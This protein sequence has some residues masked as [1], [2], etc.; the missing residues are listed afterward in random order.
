MH[1]LF[2]NEPTT[3]RGVERRF[4]RA[5]ESERRYRRDV[6]FAAKNAIKEPR[7]KRTDPKPRIEVD[8][9]GSAA[10]NRRRHEKPIAFLKHTQVFA[11]IPGTVN[12]VLTSGPRKEDMASLISQAAQRV[13]PIPVVFAK[14]KQ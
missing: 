14:L 6:T 5:G 4:A 8:V 3:R 10:F 7:G 2:A 9:L 12:L 11:Y 13:K 1:D